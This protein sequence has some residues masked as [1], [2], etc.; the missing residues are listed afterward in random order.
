LSL[1]GEPNNTRNPRS[2]G[3]GTNSTGVRTIV[4]WLRHQK[5]NRQMNDTVQ[6][7]A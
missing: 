6:L 7:P 1:G 5:F 4:A 2:F 3:C